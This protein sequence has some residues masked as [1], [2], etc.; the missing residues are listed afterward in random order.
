MRELASFDDGWRYHTNG[1]NTDG[2]AAFSLLEHSWFGVFSDSWEQVDPR[3]F[4]KQTHQTIPP[5]LAYTLYPT[6]RNRIRIHEVL[7]NPRIVLY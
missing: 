3:W 7:S 4:S 5:A 6:S 2:F 1:E